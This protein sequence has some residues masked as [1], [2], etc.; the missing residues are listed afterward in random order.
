[1][2]GKYVIVFDLDD[3][4]YKEIDFL[5][6]AYYNIST[7]LVNELKV[8][9]TVKDINNDLLA[10]YHSG[11][12]AFEKVIDKYQILSLTTKD[13]VARYREHKPIIELT[14]A[15]ISI[16]D[17]LK[18]ND[19]EMALITDGRS[20]QQ[21]AKIEAL[22]LNAYLSVIAISEEIGSE[23]PN[24]K[25]YRFVENNAKESD[26]TYVYVG[27]NLKKDFVTPNKLGWKTVLL[28]DIDRVNIHSQDLVVDQKYKATYEINSISELKDLLTYSVMSI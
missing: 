9:S 19:I 7:F 5:K 21:R 13:L 24:E 22:G 20:V 14:S 8:K 1:M 23:K 17:F 4:L 27:D 18:R 6:S 3:T 25:N 11:E 2:K 10:W 26:S 16:L 15:T 12:N 28:K